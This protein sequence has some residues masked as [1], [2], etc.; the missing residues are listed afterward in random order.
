MAYEYARLRFQWGKAHAGQ[1]VQLVRGWV[2][3][4][5]GEDAGQGAARAIDA[6]R[7][8]AGAHPGEGVVM[9]HYHEHQ[10]RLQRAMPNGFKPTYPTRKQKRKAA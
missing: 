8:T 7:S 1:Q 2:S 6:A 9:E 4:H 3:T 5:H 10:K